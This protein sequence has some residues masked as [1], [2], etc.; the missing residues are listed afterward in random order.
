MS[1]D[2]EKWLKEIIDEMH[3]QRKMKR[4]N[5]SERK[6]YNTA[7]GKQKNRKQVAKRRRQLGYKE[8]LAIPDGYCAHHIDETVVCPIPADVHQ[9]LSGYTRQTHRKL[10]LAWLYDNDP[11]LW[12][13]CIIYLRNL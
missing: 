1:F 2:W 8:L 4:H 5:L 6:Y 12:I 3:L 10:I 9:S 7:T 13:E 11:D